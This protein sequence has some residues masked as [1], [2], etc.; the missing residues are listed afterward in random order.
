MS[1]LLLSLLSI[2]HLSLPCSAVCKEQW[3][4]AARDDNGAAGRRIARGN[5]GRP[6]DWRRRP[7]I[8][9]VRTRSAV[10]HL[11]LRPSPSN[12]HPRCLAIPGEELYFRW[13]SAGLER[14][15]SFLATMPPSLP[16]YHR[17][18][19]PILLTTDPSPASRKSSPDLVN[20]SD[21]RRAAAGG[22]N[23]PQLSRSPATSFFASSSSSHLRRPRPAARGLP[24]PTPPWHRENPRPTSA[25]RATSDQ[26]RWEEITR[27]NCRA[28]RR[29]SL[30]LPSLATSAACGLPPA[31]FG[32]CC[33]RRR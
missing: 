18:R 30:P 24:L 4:A 7:W 6:G 28:G 23:P 33:H 27:H 17:C 29:P 8:P 11:S 14:W 15:R 9:A 13:V 19:P 31:C 32:R 12:P 20:K 16:L 22:D 2:P 5:R 1:S 25:I 21:E 26:R 10:A 3:R